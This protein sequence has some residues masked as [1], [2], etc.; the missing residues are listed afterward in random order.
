MAAKRGGISAEVSCPF[1]TV[2][3]VDNKSF[4]RAE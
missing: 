2:V 3:L 4:E 1:S